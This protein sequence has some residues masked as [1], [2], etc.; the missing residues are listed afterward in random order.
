VRVL[1]EKARPAALP[2][3]L[4]L[5]SQARTFAD[6][7]APPPPAHANQGGG[8]N[9]AMWA[10]LAALGAL[11]VGGYVYTKPVRDLA[12]AAKQTKDAVAGQTNEMVGVSGAVF[13]SLN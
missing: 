6:A 7:A 10:V 13:E 12:S 9:Y 2:K 5:R 3:Q 8:P 11:G 4:A 1:K